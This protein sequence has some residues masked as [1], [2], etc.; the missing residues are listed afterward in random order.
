MAHA[1]IKTLLLCI[2]YDFREFRKVLRAFPWRI[3]LCASRIRLRY[4]S[5]RHRKIYDEQS[6]FFNIFFMP[7]VLLHHFKC[8]IESKRLGITLVE[9][10]QRRCELNERKTEELN[11]KN[12]SLRLELA[13]RRKEVMG[14]FADLVPGATINDFEEFSMI[15]SFSLMFLSNSITRLIFFKR[16]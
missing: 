4:L 5:F 7:S 2:G 13:K 14:E 10:Y 15:W 6:F 16:Q 11:K 1:W 8:Q 9:F 3:K 12:Q